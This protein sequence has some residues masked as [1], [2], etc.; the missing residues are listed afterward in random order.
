MLAPQTIQY[1]DTLHLF[2]CLTSLF[3]IYLHFTTTNFFHCNCQSQN[4][5][6]SVSFFI[7]C[8]SAQNRIKMTKINQNQ[9][10][11]MIKF[12][13]K[14]YQLLYGK[15]GS[16]QRKKLKDSKWD[17]LTKMLN[18]AGP[19]TK[20][21]KIWRRVR[22][23]VF[24]FFFLKNKKMTK[25]VSLID[26]LGQTGKWMQRSKQERFCNI[27]IKRVVDRQSNFV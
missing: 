3:R 9:K 8:G 18:A 13:E 12:M 1:T 10:R 5:A 21:E 26:S 7:L 23:L 22:I 11:I 17:E 16:G 4:S 2:V 20:D 19:P 24:F 25:S 15:F 14:N 6:L 27:T